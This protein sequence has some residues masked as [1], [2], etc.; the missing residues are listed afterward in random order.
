[1]S[2]IVIAQFELTDPNAFHPNTL[3][4]DD[5]LKTAIKEYY[6]EKLEPLGVKLIE[7]KGNVIYTDVLGYGAYFEED[8]KKV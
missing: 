4:A 1:M 5:E 6:D 7:Q 8:L 3:K 2:R